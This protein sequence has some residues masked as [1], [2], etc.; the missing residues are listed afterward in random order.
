MLHITLGY[1]NVSVSLIC[2]YPWGE[3]ELLSPEGVLM[4]HPQ[5][6]QMGGIYALTAEQHARWLPDG[7][8]VGQALTAL[9]LRREK[10]LFRYD[11]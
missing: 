6:V 10:I 5:G 4:G 8:D 11:A 1:W 3:W 2:T 7:V 9:L